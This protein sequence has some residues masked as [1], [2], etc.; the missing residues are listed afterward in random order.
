MQVTYAAGLEP[1]RLARLGQA[2]YFGEQA[3]QVD[4]V[5]DE[6]SLLHLRAPL[7]FNVACRK[8]LS[9][10]SYTGGSAPK[11]PLVARK[12]RAFGGE[13][14]QTGRPAGTWLFTRFYSFLINRSLT[15]TYV[16]A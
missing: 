3:M 2:Y 10:W 12:W 14:L 7:A 8:R 1:A 16:G 11:G 6:V 15:Y 9:P 5:S 13:K 4:G